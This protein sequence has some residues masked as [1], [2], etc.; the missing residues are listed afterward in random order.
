M[1]EYLLSTGEASIGF[2]TGI[3]KIASAAL[4]LPL[5]LEELLRV[6]MKVLNI[7][8]LGSICALAGCQTNATYTQYM[9]GP[10]LEYA[11]SKCNMLAPGT[12]QG[13]VAFGSIGFV[14]GAAI[15][16]AIGNAIR[17]EEFKK[18]CMAM[19]GW[20]QDAPGAKKATPTVSPTTQ[21]ARQP[22]QPGN[23]IPSG[24]RLGIP[25]QVVVGQ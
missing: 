22:R 24:Q 18:N 23:H 7:I 3:N 10:P 6:A 8:A 14:A 4:Q 5:Q 25:S 19:Q 16:N 12:N 9:P 15:G 13:Y 21:I 17:E 2:S 1:I 20:R 11:Q